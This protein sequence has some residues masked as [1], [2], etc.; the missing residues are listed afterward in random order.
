MQRRHGGGFTLVEVLIALLILAIALM[1]AIVATQN[2]VRDT[3]HVKNKLAAHWVAM[4][5]M[6]KME[7]GALPLPTSGEQQGESTLLRNAFSWTSGV[8]Q[9]GDRFYERIYVDVTRKGSSA[10]LEHLV[11]FVKIQHPSVAGSL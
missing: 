2:S 4:N 7:V 1:A 3:D 10:R 6:A 9:A 8:D 5:V 11:G